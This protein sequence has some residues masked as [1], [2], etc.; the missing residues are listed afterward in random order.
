MKKYNLEQI[1]EMADGDEEFIL[2]M[3]KTFT[4]ELPEDIHA[5]NEAVNNGNA[6]LAYQTA[7]KMKPNLQ[8]F[9]LDLAPEVKK[10]EGWAKNSAMKEDILPYANIVS[11]TVLTACKELR[12][13]FNL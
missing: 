4:E 7:H 5:M 13:D 2:E 9:G 11:E 12:E 1:Q 6:Q 3:V 10:I 8:I